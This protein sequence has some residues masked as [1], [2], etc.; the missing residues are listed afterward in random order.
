LPNGL[1]RLRAY[2]DRIACQ[3]NLYLF[4]Q[5]LATYSDHQHGEFPRVENRPRRNVPGIIVPILRDG[6]YLSPET[7]LACPTNGRRLPDC[8]S[9]G[10]LDALCE[11]DYQRWAPALTGCYAY[12]LG[13]QDAGGR[14][15]GYRRTDPGELPIMADRPLLAKDIGSQDTS[16]RGSSP[17][18]HGQNILFLSGHVSFLA[19][20]MVV[21]H[22]IE[23]APVRDHIYLNAEMKVR[24]GHG[25]LDPVLGTGADHP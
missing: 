23:G 8:P 18:H 12:A 11:A 3:N 20:P 5:A 13:Y 1:T 21:L 10:E 9:L 22:G 15:C 24:A 14:L 19:E 2:H 6:G 25:L 4:H 7:S 17:N 16:F